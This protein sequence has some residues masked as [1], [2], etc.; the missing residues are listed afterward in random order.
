M[1]A[2]NSSSPICNS[3]RKLQLIRSTVAALAII[4]FVYF[5]IHSC[6]KD[7][8]ASPEPPSIA[9]DNVIC[10]ASDVFFTDIEF[11]CVSG[12]V[13][14]L[15]ITIDGGMT[16]KGSALP[17]GNLNDVQFLN[18]SRGWVAGKDGSLHST[19]DGGAS[20]T[21]N[22]GQGWP[23]DEDFYKVQFF[24]ENLGYLLGYR[25]VYRTNDGGASWANN[26]LPVVADRG[27]L[28]VSFVN[29]RTAFLL[30]SRYLEADPVCL[31]RTAN[32]GAQWYPVEGS[33]VS[34]L[35][36]VMTIWFVDALTGWAGGGVIMKTTDGGAT[37]ARQESSATV[38]EFFFFDSL[39]GFAVGGRTILR[40]EDGGV[41]WVNVT[42]A[43]DR[44]ADLRGVHFLDA[45]DGWVV[46]RG[47][48]VQVGGTLC[49]R[50]LVLVTSD[51][52]ATWKV[53]EFL[54]DYTLLAG[55]SGVAED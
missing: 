4:A 27:A 9:P 32:G 52:G 8:I 26:W 43:D 20:W 44:I 51:G 21:L 5:Q 6:S 47:T 16:W 54:F 38:R 23:A 31:Y 17:A 41:S 3:R 40:T 33:R 28:D 50:S 35:R 36:T 29:D 18:R 24:N 1:D 46:G 34:V 37:W 22:P 48:D 14:T 45:R 30:G 15:M 55:M 49:K 7:R 11:G 42:P 13:G 2:G 25:G 12:T 19:L 53:R 10:A 39:R